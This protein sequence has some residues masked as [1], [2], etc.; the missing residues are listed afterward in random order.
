VAID[1]RTSRV[2]KS[3]R[4]KYYKKDYIDKMK[5][6]SDAKVQGVFYCVD[7]GP[8]SSTP[9][10]AGNVMQRQYTGSIKT[11]DII[12]DLD[13]NDYVLYDGNLFLVTG[14]DREDNDDQKWFSNSPSIQT[15]IRLRR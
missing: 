6:V 5:L 15:T 13:V 2:G 4:V 9:I 8:F 11:E 14:I 10:S 3:N 12:D 7:N 1:T